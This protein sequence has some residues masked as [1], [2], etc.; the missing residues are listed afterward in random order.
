MNN[1]FNKIFPSFFLFNCEFL[2]GNRLIDI[3]PNCFSFHFLNRKS[4]NSIKNHLHNLNNITLQLLI[5]LYLAVVILD[6]SIKNYVAILIA[7]VYVHNSPTIK[8]IHHAVDII[9][10]KVELFVIRCGINQATHL[11]NI[12]WIFIIMDSIH[13]TKRIFNSST[14]SYQI[15]SAAISYKLRKFFK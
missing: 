10:T 6:T 1:R 3:F 7:H 2:L 14:H 11:P 9:F 5:D 12:N 15:Y 8:T 13:T 4:E